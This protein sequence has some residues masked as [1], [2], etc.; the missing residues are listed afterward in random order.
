MKDKKLKLGIKEVVAS[1]RSCWYVGVRGAIRNLS[2]P[3]LWLFDCYKD[4]RQYALRYAYAKNIETI[5]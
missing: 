2:F 4:A 3:R 1:G 5:D